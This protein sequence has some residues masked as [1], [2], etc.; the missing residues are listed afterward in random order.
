MESITEAL[1]AGASALTSLLGGPLQQ[2][3]L[4]QLDTPLDK[5]A[6]GQR[7]GTGVCV[8]HRVLGRSS[9]ADHFS[10]TVDAVSARDDIPLK[11]LIAQPVTL[12]IQQDS[13][14]GGAGVAGAGASGDRSG[15]APH[16][17]YVHTARRLGGD[18]S[19]TTYQLEFASWLHFLKFRK[20]ARIWQDK[21]ADQIITDVFQVHPQAQGAFRF[22]LSG[23]LA[24]RSFCVQYESDWDFVHRLMEQE[25]LYGYFE[26]AA[27]GTHHTFV[28]TDQLD[29][30]QPMQPQQVAF[31]RAGTG[32]QTDALTQWSDTRT[33][34]SVALST[35][36]YDYK[37]PATAVQPKATATQTMATQGDL[38]QQAEVYE[39]TG[40]YTFNAQGRGDTLSKIRM[41]EWESRAKRFHGVGGVRGVD[42]GRWFELTSHPALALDSAAQRQFAVLAVQ[43]SIENNLP[44]SLDATDYPGSLKAELAAIRKRHQD[45][46][47]D[48]ANTVTGVIQRATG[49]LS[50][51]GQSARASSNAAGDSAGFYLVEIETQRRTVPYRAP[52]AHPKPPMTLQTATVSGPQ[53]EAVYTDS[54]NRI[55]ILMHWDRINGGDE[56]A[57]CWVRVVQ[58]DG[59]ASYGSV[60]PP[61]VG[62][63]VI[64][65]WLDGDCDRPVVVGRVYNGS[66]TPD[67]HSNGILSGYKS[68]EYGGSGYNQLVMDDASGQNRVQ[69]ASSSAG[70]QLHLGYLIAQSGNTRGAYLGTG[71]DLSSDAQGAV[72]AVQGLYLGT[73]PATQQPMAV[74]TARAQLRASYDAA[75]ALSTASTTAGAAS[76]AEGQAALKDFT[77]ATEHTQQGAV[78]GSAADSSSGTNTAGGGTGNANGFSKPVMLLAS[79]SG[80]GLSTQDAIHLAAN[81]QTTVVSG[82]G[83]NLAVGRSLLASVGQSLSLFAQN[84]GIK[85]FAGKGAVQVQAQDDAIE[86]TAQKGVKV[87]SVTDLIEMAADKDVLLTSGGAYIRI[88]GGNIQIHAPGQVDIKGADHPFS[89]PTSQGY[90]LPSPR[91]DTP[92]QLEIFHD[93][94]AKGAPVAGGRYTVAD[95]D[96]NTLRSGA[97]D[98]SGHTVVSGIPAG[99]ARVTLGTD[100][101][102]PTTTPIAVEETFKWPSEGVNGNDASAAS[103]A[104]SVVPSQAGTTSALGA[105]IKDEAT[106]RGSAALLGV[107]GNIAP[108]A[109]RVASAARSALPL[110]KGM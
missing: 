95:A 55:K 103:S 15:Y 91:P 65:D 54:L 106:Q 19:L 41:Q 82:Q 78:A 10:F 44:V 25:G 59:G 99:A 53:N 88:S 68:R 74:D 37:A 46:A 60:H 42:V 80:I 21:T 89:G 1:G 47:Q 28:I 40:A 94:V 14:T 61:R 13:G 50:G 27:D 51:S 63:E 72:R 24:Q 64:V 108:Q 26:Q 77:D 52:F 101:R 104:S 90:P 9:A 58:S 31:S 102:N 84:A 48:H 2:A 57:S 93:Y 18:G 36:T 7:T 4:L 70:T 76:L 67:W 109:T 5:N 92:G 83:T 107:A 73:H 34:Q 30:F 79:P 35:R 33:L 38:P 96:G 8:P 81:D 16:H 75:D 17:G 12:W 11:A 20:D 6:Q 105:T 32:A 97:L 87:L 3:R 85:L 56:N 22:V 45:S 71:F 43:W 98:A 100:P 66:T 69:L 23:A 86:M 39:Y 62:E 110:L 49:L 29:T